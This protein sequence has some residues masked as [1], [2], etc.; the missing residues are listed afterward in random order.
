MKNFIPIVIIL[1][2]CIVFGGCQDDGNVQLDECEES[3]ENNIEF[4]D[5]QS[6]N[7]NKVDPF[8]IEFKKPIIYLYPEEVQEIDVKLDYT[9]KLMCTYPLYNNGWEVIAHPNGKLINLNDN[10]EYSYLFWEG[11]SDYKW[12]IDKGF[13]VKGDRTVEFLQDKLSYLGLEPKEYNDFIT[14]WLPIMQE[15]KYNLIHFAEEDYEN[16][17]KLSIEPKPDSIL[18]VFMVFKAL[19][20]CINIEEQELKTFDRTGFTVIEWGGSEI[21]N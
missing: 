21:K 1:M 17:A 14:Y 12:N 13:V 20:E 9:G 18:R 5:D 15:N 10:R 16:L 6:M 4:N 7:N 2:L 8:E 11:I 3:Q 19:D